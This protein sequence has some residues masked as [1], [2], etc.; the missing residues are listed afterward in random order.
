[1]ASWEAAKS[2]SFFNIF[3]SLYRNTGRKK[4]KSQICEE[5]VFIRHLYAQPSGGQETKLFLRMA[6]GWAGLGWTGL[7]L[8]HPV[9]NVLCLG[10]CN[11]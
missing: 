8:K 11:L 1:M 9:S 4:E 3:F 5:N 6:P 7:G 2:F 10:N